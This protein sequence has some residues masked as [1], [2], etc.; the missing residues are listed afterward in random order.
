MKTILQQL[1]ELGQ[2]QGLSQATLARAPDIDGFAQTLAAI[3]A[4]CATC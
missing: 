3:R 4:A 1:V 2:A